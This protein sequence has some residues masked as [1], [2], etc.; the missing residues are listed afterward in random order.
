MD[1]VLVGI[2]RFALGEQ[3]RER[4]TIDARML[5]FGKNKYGIFASMIG[6]PS[7]QRIKPV[8]DDVVFVQAMVQ[9][10][11]FAPGVS[12]HHLFVGLQDLAPAGRL[13]SGTLLRA[14]Q[15]ARTA[16]GYLGAWPKPGVLDVLQLGETQYTDSFGYSRL[17]LGLWRLETPD[18]FS[19]VA[20]DRGILARVAPQLA[21]EQ[22]EDK[23]QVRVDVGDISTS[24]FGRWANELDYRRAYQTSAG[25]ARFLHMLSQQLHVPRADALAVG[26]SLL[27]LK[28]ICALGGEY[29]LQ[30]HASGLEHWVSTKWDSSDPAP[31]QA[32]QSPLMGWFRGLSGTLTML[33]DRL[34]V[35]AE[36]DMERSEIDRGVQLPL[37][38]LFRGK[39]K[40]DSES[41]GS[42]EFGE[43]QKPKAQKPEASPPPEELPPPEPAPD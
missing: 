14:L 6:P 23:A 22:V 39:K 19:L 7:Q 30:T 35:Q 29:Q 1:P 25:N 27:D 33:D 13:A 4:V 31:E 15:I 37:F 9:G 26:E 41:A 38:N 42:P 18:G 24:K 40:Q 11:P 16:P 20:F 21:V 43:Q 17:P 34:L 3:N 28:L 10:G 12:P 36:I 8:P 5:P 2:R 32:Y